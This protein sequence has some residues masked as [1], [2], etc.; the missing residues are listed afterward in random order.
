MSSEEVDAYL[1]ELDEPK[2]S[3]LERL[4]DMI[5]D[6]VPEAEQGISYGVPVF[7]LEGRNIAGFSAAK[8]HLSY[9]PHSG[10]VLADIDEAELGGLVASKGALKL[11]IDDLPPPALVARLIELRRAEAGI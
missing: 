11:P 5:L 4:R 2:R 7:R 3:T 10:T 6:A 9:L 1:A 8:N